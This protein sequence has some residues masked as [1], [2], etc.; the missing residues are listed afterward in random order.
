M[1][2]RRSLALAAALA[3]VILCSASPSTAAP[4]EGRAR[5]IALPAEAAHADLDRTVESDRPARRFAVPVDI[6][7]TGV[8]VEGLPASLGAYVLRLEYD[9]SR[10]TV[11]SVRGGNA[12]FAEIPVATDLDKANAAGRL[13]LTAVQVSPEKAS[14]SF[15]SRVV[16]AE[17]EPGGRETVKVRVH[18]LS[19]PL[20]QRASSGSGVHATDAGQTVYSIPVNQ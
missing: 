13:G 8:V 16:F 15:A 5:A 14:G 20:V 7:L 3:T 1:S 11:L 17:M 6:D 19:T 18:S 9:P 4:P 2:I 10:V 12:P